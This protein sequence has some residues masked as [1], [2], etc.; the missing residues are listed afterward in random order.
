MIWIYFGRWFFKFCLC[1]IIEWKL[2]FSSNILIVEPE[3]IITF[4]SVS[5]I[6]TGWVFDLFPIWKTY[7]SSSL[8]THF[9]LLQFWHVGLVDFL[10]ENYLICFFAV[11]CNYVDVFRV[12]H[13]LVKCP[14][15][16]QLCHFDFDFGFCDRLELGVLLHYI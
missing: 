1:G 13:M 11:V 5:F 14:N 12:L 8:K 15:F 7:T 2:L 10:C 3:S 6:S 4:I 16:P 9:L